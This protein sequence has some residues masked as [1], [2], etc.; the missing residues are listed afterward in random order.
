MVTAGADCIVKTWDLRTYKCAATWRVP[1]QTTALEV[2]QRGLVGLAFGAKAQVWMEGKAGWGRTP[3]MSQPYAG[4]RVTGLEFCPFEDLMAVCWETGVGKMVVPGAGE[5]VF[6]SGAPNPYDT[7]RQKRE[8]EVRG[9]L[10]KLPIG[11][12]VLDTSDIGG[13]EKDGRARLREIRDRGREANAEKRKKKLEVN[14]AKGRNKI[15]KRLRRRQA[16]VID[17][18]RLAMQDK[19]EQQRKTREAARK[20]KE[21]RDREAREGVGEGGLSV[22]QVPEALKRFLPKSER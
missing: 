18:K 11:S 22:K 2:S 13:I 10:D 7:K 5:A 1:A 6:D 19:L 20:V 8:R 16:N 21:K 14:R 17:E 9:L 3:Y 12:I 4:K 15:S